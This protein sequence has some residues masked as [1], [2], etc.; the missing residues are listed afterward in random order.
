MLIISV[1]F[2]RGKITLFVCL[3]IWG[4]SSHSRYFH[5]FGDVTFAGWRAAD[6]ELCLA[7][8]S[9]EQW[10]LFSV[11]PTLI[12]VLLILHKAVIIFYK[13]GIDFHHYFVSFEWD[14][15]FF[16][17]NHRPQVWVF[18]KYFTFEFIN[19]TDW[20]RGVVSTQN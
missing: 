14:N 11:S 19:I 3:F 4:F 2:I 12:R 20:S 10:G 16:H 9:I 5:S 15:D 1:R 18:V 7:L 13:Y 17:K 8:I 6:F